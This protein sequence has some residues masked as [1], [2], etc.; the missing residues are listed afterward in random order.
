MYP[1]AV[2]TNMVAM[3]PSDAP[4][5]PPAWTPPL[6]LEERIRWG[7]VPGRW[8][9]RYRIRKEKRRGER[10]LSLLPF[11][12]PRGRVALDIGANIGVWAEE[13]R[14]CG[15]MVHAFEPNPKLFGML[16]SGAAPNGVALHNLALSDRAGEAVLMVPRGR[17]GF[18]NQGAT[19]SAEKIG[20]REFGAVTVSTARLD[21]LGLEDVGFM[22]IDV[23]GHELAVIAGAERTIARWRPALVVELEER[24]TK[25]PIEQDLDQ[26]RALG[27]E[28]FCLID[29]VL[30]LV[31]RVDLDRHHRDPADRSAYVFNWI[32]LPR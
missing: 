27:Y 28:A 6:T 2:F 7:I 23:E 4:A 19:L 25:R 13:M 32:F 14:R 5:S 12:C 16:R 21:D 26:I 15:A 31:A 20:E 11:L 8:T 9:L 17:R 24:H 10:E 30:T 22:K 18:S 3:P 29:G 1:V